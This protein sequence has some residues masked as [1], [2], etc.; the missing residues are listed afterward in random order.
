V[1]RLKALS[2]DIRKNLDAPLSG[3]HVAL[4]EQGLGD[5]SIRT[6][7]R[8]GDTPAGER[9]RVG[10]RPPHMDVTTP[11]SLYVLLGSESGRRH[12]GDYPN[13]DRR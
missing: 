8:T 2:N 6:W 4:R 9:K 7:V 5:V 13:S 3:I 11:E 10:R 1:S 12:A